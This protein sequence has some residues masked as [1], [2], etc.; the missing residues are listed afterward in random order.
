MSK[1]KRKP[2]AD[3]TPSMLVAIGDDAAAAVSN[4]NDTRLSPRR[5]R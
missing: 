5:R 1:P 2:P 4:V 3:D